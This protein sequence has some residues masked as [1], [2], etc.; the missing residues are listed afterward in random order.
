MRTKA[1]KVYSITSARRALSE[2]V[3]ARNLRYL[4]SMSIRTACFFLAFVVTGPLRWVCFAAAVILPWIS[5]MVANSGRERPQSPTDVVPAD[6][7]AVVLHT[8][9]YLR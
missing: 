6:D 2:D 3:R 7:H 4:V 1:G 5:V 9:E 8:G